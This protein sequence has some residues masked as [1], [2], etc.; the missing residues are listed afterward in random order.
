MVVFV[1]LMVA[2]IGVYSQIYTKQ[3]AKGV[4]QQSGVASAMIAWHSTAVDLASKFVKASSFSTTGCTLT[5]FVSSPSTPVPAS[6]PLCTGNKNPTYVGMTTTPICTG[7]VGPPCVTKLPEGYLSSP[8]TF[9]SIAFNT[10]GGKSYVLTY[11]PPP[12]TGSYGLGLLCLPGKLTGTACPAGHSQFSFTFNSLYKQITKSPLLSPMTYGTVTSAGV[13]STRTMNSLYESTTP[14]SLQY[15]VP[16]DI[17]IV[18]EGT[19]GII[20]EIT[21]C[22]STSC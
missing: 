4:E 7:S 18:P 22:S 14:Q 15:E 10:S 5:S 21:R 1:T 9:Y 16:N 13:L 11:V 19:I 8:Y 12:P 17:S 2:L 6:L 3:S 20:T